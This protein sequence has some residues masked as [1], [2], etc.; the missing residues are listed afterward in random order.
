MRIG[1]KHLQNLFADIGDKLG[2]SP[3][4]NYSTQNPT[5]GVWFI[6]NPFNILE[7]TPLVAIEIL[8]S[9]SP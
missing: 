6:R 2:Y 9:E 7:Q 8:V 5:D 4:R 1:H 3:K